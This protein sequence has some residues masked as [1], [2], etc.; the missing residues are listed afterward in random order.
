MAKRSNIAWR[1]VLSAVLAGTIMLLSGCSMGK[2]SLYEN[3]PSDYSIVYD[4]DGAQFAIPGRFISAATAVTEIRE[5]S[6]FDAAWTYLYKNGE[7]QYMLFSMD[8]IV[9]ACAK[10]THFDF[11]EDEDKTA[12]LDNSSIMG[13]WTSAVKKNLDYTDS[14]DA[15]SEYKIIANTTAE[16]ALTTNLF[17]DFVGKL[18]SIKSGD[19]EWSLFAG[20][21]GD[22]MN[23]IPKEQLSVINSIAKSLTTGNAD[24]EEIT[25]EYSAGKAD[26]ENEEAQ[27]SSEAASSVE[28]KEDTESKDAAADTESSEKADTGADE[29][30]KNESDDNDTEGDVKDP[31]AED[32]KEN[33]DEESD[34]SSS[35][36]ES[37]GGEEPAG[38]KSSRGESKAPE[39][40]NLPGRDE[41]TDGPADDDENDAA[42]TAG[43]VADNKDADESGDETDQAIEEDTGSKKET[44][45]KTITVSNQKKEEADKITGAKA[46][47]VYSLLSAGEKGSLDA[48]SDTNREEEK[49]AVTLVKTCQG[50][51]AESLITK[52]AGSHDS[53]PVGTQWTVAVYKADF[54][55]LDDEPY[56]DVK[57]LGVDGEKLRHA[58]ITY[59]SRTY[60]MDEDEDGNM[61][62]YYAVPYNCAEYVLSFGEGSI[63]NDRSAAY[64][65][66]K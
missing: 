58:G 40:G 51:D 20:V 4:V 18:S 34:E 53:A 17:G 21:P 2:T 24:T 63:S 65:L 26:T 42:D 13:I 44:S 8:Q 3:A 50:S 35:A 56:I 59:P 39:D 46:S 31:A 52:Y 61:M 22:S 45:S 15:S 30:S 7:D 62:V 6:D 49:A 64:Y 1:G 19:T 11:D 16:V 25:Y 48:Y 38:E 12:A 28:T 55:G 32:Q 9:I 14:G 10:N 5:D 27:E 41:S 23:D 54:T 36:P 37:E 33:P 47:S 66:V 43:S 57:F 60:D 29:T